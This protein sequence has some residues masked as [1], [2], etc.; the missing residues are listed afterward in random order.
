MNF[1]AMKKPKKIG[2]LGGM[3]PEATLCLYNLIIKNTKAAKDQDHIP[4]IINANP[5]IP[6]RTLH[7]VYNRESPLPYLQEEASILMSAGADMIIIACNTAHY[8]IDEIAQVVDIPVLNMIDLTSSYI[9]SRENGADGVRVGILATTGTINTALYQNSLIKSGFT[10]LIPEGEDQERLVME[11]VYGTKG[12]KAGY[13]RGAK[14]L[15]KEAAAKLEQR[16]AKYIIAGCTEIPIV[17]TDRDIDSTLVN[18]MEI[19]AIEAIKRAK[20]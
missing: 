3:G 10:P 9:S 6:D 2:I 15:L 17:L 13:K 1:V 7:I 14:L 20:M 12:V 16:G 18:S 5:L 8:Y 19:L 11:A 4:V